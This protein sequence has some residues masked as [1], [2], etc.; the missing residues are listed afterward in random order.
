MV[1][2]KF[3]TIQ[4]FSFKDTIDLTIFFSEAQNESLIRFT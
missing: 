2:T 4:E 1:I 3:N